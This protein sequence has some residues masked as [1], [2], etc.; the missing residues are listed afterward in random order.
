MNT[1]VIIGLIVAVLVV[2]G[3]TFFFTIE[4]AQAPEN[5]APEDVTLESSPTP[6]DTGDSTDEGPGSSSED[7]DSAPTISYNGDSYLPATVTISVGDTVTFANK[8]TRDM[9]P[10][11]AMHPTHTVYPGSDIKKCNTAKDGDLFDSC[12]SIS[13]GSS[14]SFTFTEPGQWKYHDH[15]NPKS[16]GTIIVE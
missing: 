16:T 9:W 2:I 14:W 8:S 15:L 6:S 11:S 7:G 5:G 3:G 10:A 13:Q 12:K 1:N 4:Q